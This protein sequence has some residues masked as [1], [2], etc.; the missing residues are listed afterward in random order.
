LFNT[1]ISGQNFLTLPPNRALLLPPP[2][3]RM[4]RS[5][6]EALGMKVPK[7]ERENPVQPTPYTIYTNR[8]PLLQKNSKFRKNP[9]KSGKF[10]NEIEGGF[11]PTEFSVPVFYTGILAFF[12]FLLPFTQTLSNLA[13]PP[14]NL[15]AHKGMLQCSVAKAGLIVLCCLPACCPGCPARACT[16][17]SGH[18]LLATVVSTR[19]LWAKLWELVLWFRVYDRYYLATKYMQNL[20]LHWNDCWSVL[21]AC[22]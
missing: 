2:S 9:G 3:H 14:S 12:P 4:P 7:E 10:K 18:G 16:W 11:F 20:Y 1:V 15:L 13:S 22:A 19:K 8:I 5:E 17:A 6:S 21:V